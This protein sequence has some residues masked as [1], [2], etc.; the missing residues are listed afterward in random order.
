MQSFKP[1]I[2]SFLGYMLL[3]MAALYAQVSVSTT[4][5][6]REIG[7]GEVGVFVIS[8]QA[9]NKQIQSFDWAED[10]PLILPQSF[11][12]IQKSPEQSLNI[13][14]GRV[15]QTL[16]LKFT[17]RATQQ[18]TFTIPPFDLI[19]DN[20][21][22]FIGSQ[23][24]TVG[25]ASEK[26]EAILQLFMERDAVY[27][28][29]LMLANLKLLIP[30]HLRLDF[31]NSS[32]KATGDAF[33]EL[34]NDV[35]AERPERV[36]HKGQSFL[37]YTL[38]TR[39]IP[40]KSG[41]RTLRFDL[42]IYAHKDLGHTYVP[43]QFKVSTDDLTVKVLPLPEANKPEHFTGAVGSFNIKN[44]TP[45]TKGLRVGEPIVYTLVFE[46]EGNF[47]RIVPPTLESSDIWEIYEPK[48]E[49]KQ[50]NLLSKHGQAIV[51][52]IMTPLSGA[53]QVIPPVTFS[54]FDPVKERYETI[55][56]EPIPVHIAGETSTSI[57][58]TPQK[59]TP[60][61]PSSD[62]IDIRPSQTDAPT[63][64][65]HLHHS[66]FFWLTHALLGMTWLACY[67]YARKAHKL[68][69]DPDYALTHKLKKALKRSLKHSQLNARKDSVKFYHSAEE[70][71]RIA[72]GLASKSNPE[73]MT[74]TEV[75]KL[76]DNLELDPAL[77]LTAD[78]LLNAA[79]SS[80]YAGIQPQTQALN[81]HMQAL[82]RLIHHL[83]K[84]QP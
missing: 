50:D 62:Y 12:V 21:R 27:V 78:N 67:G 13:I 19:I 18:G 20:Q 68:K 83:R 23:K 61:K 33:N 17:I 79:E 73:S 28:G 53:E 9:Q 59:P 64:L 63:T 57:E 34:N 58:T 40:V 47:Q 60:Q 80:K 15:S 29:E 70:T 22:H 6:P 69:N 10:K 37:V 26:Q 30:D 72:L 77:R 55:N 32:L 39:L 84:Y 74:R 45:R 36:T 35:I 24:I 75:E 31:S 8:I 65:R 44:Y 1:I 71:L 25:E 49:V 81:T 51:N 3:G 5:T 48:I 76:L 16:H 56:L 7:V 43:T 46:G 52:Y 66:P 82:E 41:D 38:R 14:N 2:I 54:Y 11:E 42:D 4:F